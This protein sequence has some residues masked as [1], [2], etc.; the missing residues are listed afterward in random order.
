M[1][2][3]RK[4]LKGY[5]VYW[6]PSGGVDEFGRRLFGEPVEVRCRWEGRAEEFMTGSGEKALSKARVYVDRDLETLGVLWEGRLS[7]AVRDDPFA[8]TDAWEVRRFERMPDLRY[9]DVL[10]TAYL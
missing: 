7:Q 4:M 8:N 2:I 1:R 3:I 6:S 9:K 5:A 10:R